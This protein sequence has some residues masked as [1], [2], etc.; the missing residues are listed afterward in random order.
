MKTIPFALSCCFALAILSARGAL[1]A[2]DSPGAPTPNLV[3]NPGFETYAAPPIGWFYKGRHFTDVMKYWSSPTAASPDVFGPRVRVPRQWAEKDFGDQPAHGG[4]S[5]VGITC[6]GCEEGKP[7]C[8]EYVQVQ[9]LE[10]LIVGQS[11]EVAFWVNHLPRSLQ[12]DGLGA[13]FASEKTE[14]AGEARLPGPPQVSAGE[15]VRCP[16]GAWTEISGRFTA[17]TA[18]NYLIIGNFSADQQTRIAMPCSDHL[19]FAY[20]YIDD[21]SVRKV[22]PILPVPAPVDDLATL[23]VEEGLVVELKNIFFETDKDEL[24]PR[25]FIE[26]NKLLALMGRQPSMVIRINGHTDNQGADDYNL[27]LSERRSRAVVDFLLDQGIDP[28]RVS[29]RGFGSTRP[30]ADNGTEAGRQLNRRVEFVVL[31]M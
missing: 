28:Q 31:K 24:L 2:Q 21:V 16:D 26:L 9:L 30:I 25:S 1:L 27:E 5:M 19:N 18:A 3:P 11:Y 29:Y 23:K 7:H 17:A 6:Y 10:P 12:I 22:E 20:Y 8:R 4:V 15:I 14:I 13:F